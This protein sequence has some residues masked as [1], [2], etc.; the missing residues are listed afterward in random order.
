[1]SQ[2]LYTVTLTAAE[3]DLIETIIDRKVGATLIPEPRATLAARRAAKPNARS[4][5]WR[6]TGPPLESI[7]TV[8]STPALEAWLERRATP[9][10]T[11]RPFAMPAPSKPKKLTPQ[12]RASVQARWGR[13]IETPAGWHVELA[14]GVSKPCG[15]ETEDDVAAAWGLPPVRA[16]LVESQ[17]GVT[18]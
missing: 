5:P 4:K 7:M 14:S 16:R 9:G 11:P 2:P 17:L 10:Y 8:P 18:E 3:V 6:P 12:Q 1:M 15:Y 13:A